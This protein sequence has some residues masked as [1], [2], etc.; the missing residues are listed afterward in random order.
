MW[1]LRLVG[2]IGKRVSTSCFE[3]LRRVR[4]AVE[5]FDSSSLGR[6]GNE[7]R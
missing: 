1:F 7:K 6:G 3:P 2:W 5:A 4:W